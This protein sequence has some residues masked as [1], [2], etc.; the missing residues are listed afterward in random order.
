MPRAPRPRWNK[1]RRRWYANIGEPDDKG[2]RREVFAPESLGERDEGKAWEWFHEAQ[3]RREAEVAPVGADVTAEWVCEHYLVWAEKRRDE[4]KLPETEYRNKARHLGI[5]A[6]L[7]GK[8]A[9]RTITPDDMTAFGER[10]LGGYSPTY[11]RNVCATAR[12]ALNWA[13]KAKHLEANPIRGFKA[14]TVPRSPARFAERAEAAAFVGFW[15]G[16]ADRET[17]RGQYD[18]LTLLLERILI[19]TGARPKELCKLQWSDLRWQGWSTSAGHV[20]AKAVIPP[21]RWKAGKVTGKPRTIYFTPALTRALR[22]VWERGAPDPTWVFVHGAGR[23]G[24]GA[25]QPWPNG[26]SLS[27]TILK[28]RRRLIA[29]QEGIRKR[30]KAGDAV[31]AWEARRAAVDV[32]DEGHDRLVNYRWRHTAIS[33]LL[34]LGVDVPTVAELTGTSPEMIYRHYGHLLDSHLQ[35]AAERLAGPAKPKAKPKAPKGRSDPHR[36]APESGP[37]VR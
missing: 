15:R 32:R 33:T 29:D 18:R 11:A 31:G 14:P 1:G 13:V 9:V 23:G 12:A 30:L 35:S 24:H 25:G 4:G 21:D 7:L 28:V 27:K 3:R 20:A 17:V 34:M 2:R 16:R 26:S 5:F 36:S 22:R 6:A 10:L 8:R 19:R 37:P